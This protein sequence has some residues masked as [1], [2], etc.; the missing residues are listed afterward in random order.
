M[1]CT[2]YREKDYCYNCPFLDNGKAIYLADGRLDSI[3]KQL[4][5]SD[6]ESFTCHNTLGIEGVL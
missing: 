5:I 1:D 2:I 6:Y 3:K 4:L